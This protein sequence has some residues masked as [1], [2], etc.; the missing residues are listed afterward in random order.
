MKADDLV[1][2]EGLNHASK[3]ED[4]PIVEDLLVAGEDRARILQ[5]DRVVLKDEDLRVVSFFCQPNA[6]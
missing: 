5:K 3:V 2:K 6:L 4:V 1:A